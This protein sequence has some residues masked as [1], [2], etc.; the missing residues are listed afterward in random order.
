MNHPILILSFSA[1]AFASTNGHLTHAKS[2]PFR[3]GF[4]R[5]NCH[6]IHHAS[7]LS[8]NYVALIFSLVIDSSMPIKFISAIFFVYVLGRP[9]TYSE[10]SL[11]P[12]LFFWLF[13][14]YFLLLFQ[15]EFLP[16]ISSAD[17]LVERLFIS[18]SVSL[19]PCL[20]YARTSEYDNFSLLTVIT[21]L[22]LKSFFFLVVF[23]LMSLALF[24]LGNSSFFVYYSFFLSAVFLSKSL[25]LLRFS[26]RGLLFSLLY[27][28]VYV[29]SSI[30]SFLFLACF[31][32][33]ST[34]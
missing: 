10:Y 26:L 1:N 20:A 31:I 25:A 15:E 8:G 6:F 11:G 9:C 16:L 34:A 5:A 17:L 19:I 22:F 7:F 12:K 28:G 13:D 30:L 33:L 3:R 23:L 21:M 4:N 29:W 27:L 18:S 2:T 14:S 24:F 32:F